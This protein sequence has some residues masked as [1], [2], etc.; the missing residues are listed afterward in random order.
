MITRP[1]FAEVSSIHD[2]TAAILQDAITAS[3]VVAAQPV[4]KLVSMDLSKLRRLE[5]W[6]GRGFALRMTRKTCFYY[7][8][9][10]SQM[11]STSKAKC[12][13]HCKATKVCRNLFMGNCWFEVACL[14]DR[15]VVAK[16][17]EGSLKKQS[18]R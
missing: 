18:R 12:T 8:R 6:K 5:L 7:T 15:G 10:Y 2:N 11:T 9:E 1:K 3:L 14:T 17:L 16:V 13:N 4:A